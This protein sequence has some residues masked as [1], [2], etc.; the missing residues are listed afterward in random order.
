[1]RPPQR[2]PRQALALGSEDVRTLRV[3]YDAY[4]AL[5]RT[6]ELTEIAPRLAAVDPDFGGSKLVEQAAELWNAGQADKAASLARLAL[7]IEPEPAPRPTTSSA[8]TTSREARTPRPR[9]RS[10]NSSI[11]RPTTPRRRRPGRC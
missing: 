5:G 4:D 9:R 11:W 10:R 8:S 7:A 3:L 2:R 1:M 6:E